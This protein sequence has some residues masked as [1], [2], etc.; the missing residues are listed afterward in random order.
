MCGISGL[1]NLQKSLSEL[2]ELGIS[3]NHSLQHRGPDNEDS[4]VN[5]DLGI[6]LNHT[7]L[8]IHD[9]SEAG[10]QPMKSN[11][12]R[13]L[14]TFNGEIYNYKEIKEELKYSWRS[15]S[16]TEVFLGAVEE[17]G[18]DKALE[19]SIGM[20]A[21]A[22]LDNKEEVLHLVRDRI[23]EKPLYWGF[24]SESND[25]FII[26][27]S[28]LNAF[29]AIPEFRNS[30]NIQSL[31][32]LL[33]Y[34]YIPSPF[35]I[36]NKIWKL[37]AGN[38]LSIKLPIQE[39][40]NDFKPKAWWKLTDVI[41]HEREALIK[42]ETEAI[43]LIKE[44]L[45]RSVLYQSRAD[46]K[47]TSFLSGG[48]DSSLVTAI[49]Q[50]QNSKKINTFTV[51]FESE[52]L[53]EAPFAKKIADYL[54]TE[55]T[56]LM[57][58]DKDAL[59]I[60]P[61]FHNFYSEPFADPAAIPTLLMCKAARQSGFKVALSG[62]GADEVF[63]GYNRYTLAP[64]I[65]ERFS[66]IDPKLRPLILLFIKLI[67]KNF[68]EKSGRMFGISQFLERVEKLSYRLNY[69]NSIDD[70]YFL[71]IKEWHDISIIMHSNQKNNIKTTNRIGINTNLESHDLQSI[72][73]MMALDCLSYL[74]D[75]NQVKLDRASMAFGL[76]TRSPFLD[77]VLID[78][79]WRLPETMKVR[80]ATGKVI[81][82]NILEG[83][84]PKKIFDRSKSG[85]AT[86]IK[87]WLRGPLKEWASDLLQADELKKNDYLDVQLISNLWNDHIGFKADNS[88]RL[89]PILIWQNWL[90]NNK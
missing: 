41:N 82:K 60:I 29:K 20:F 37:P 31:S 68:I 2:R 57:F 88:K 9:L 15:T 87:D 81:L 63:G 30:I 62:D 73:K 79:S 6:L 4:Y 18:L 10:N 70:L 1:I 19:K 11:S 69:A 40:F 24:A 53:N 3:M 75:N 22:L 5:E 89:W 23:G 46:V 14:I 13:Y 86:P 47:V 34:G 43:I 51:G 85:F 84:L 48:I 67:P 54:D 66:R 36:F 7:R 71:L 21:F 76:E 16:D 58:T 50:T 52:D 38:I 8:S 78:Y 83:Y 17:W 55:H 44:N 90:C 26:F 32:L 72:S 42:D 27:G 39:K 64:K 49:L 80:N 33:N 28:E 59:N 25:K 35:S 45:K 74:P 77:K 12:G 61:N 56:E 65:W